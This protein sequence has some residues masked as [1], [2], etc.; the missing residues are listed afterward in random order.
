MFNKMKDFV[1]NHKKG[2]AIGVG[3]TLTAGL[4][5]LLVLL[6]HGDCSDDDTYEIPSGEDTTEES[7]DEN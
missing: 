5:G 1:K 6:N 2:V 7:S 4:A 3:S